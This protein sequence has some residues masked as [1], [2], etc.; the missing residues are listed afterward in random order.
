[1]ARGEGSG[2]GKGEGDCGDLCLLILAFFLPPVAVLMK[3][4]CGADFLINIL[5]TILGII[6]GMIHAFW[7]VLKKH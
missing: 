3:A 6:P 4:G 7:V 2:D 5:L 1:M